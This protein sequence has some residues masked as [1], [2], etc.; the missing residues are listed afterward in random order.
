MDLP[1]SKDMGRKNGLNFSRGE[2]GARPLI[3]RAAVAGTF[4]PDDPE[5]LRRGLTN[6][7]DAAEV[8]ALT[9]PTALIVPHAGYA[10]SGA[11][12]ASAY[13][14]VRAHAERYQ[15]V[16]L[17]GTAHMRNAV[18]L[19]GTGVQAFETPLGRM[20][21]D[22]ASVSALMRLTDGHYDEPQQAEDHALEMQVPFL[23]VCGLKCSVI[24]LL[25][26]EVDPH[27][28]AEAVDRTL[29]VPETLVVV[30][31]DLSHYHAI[32]EA[33]QRD[34]RTAA[35]IESLE[36]ERLEAGSACGH[37]AIRV[38]LKLAVVHGWRARTIMLKTSG[39]VGGDR[40]RV[41]GYG[42]FVFDDAHQQTVPANLER[43][44]AV[45]SYLDAERGVGA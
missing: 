15:R 45:L 29:A 16:L 4:Y 9:A 23:Q 33:S 14:S 41:V 17:L 7:L 5:R 38:L 2:G 25:V 18:G 24:P 20:A 30:S 44:T 6:L 37:W 13:V 39:D 34:Q 10:Y 35:A 11:V 21:V 42:A 40:Q 28:V 22:Q 31:S 26:G 32:E 3:R 8:G 12:A 36:S 27:V 1:Q 19:I 43:T